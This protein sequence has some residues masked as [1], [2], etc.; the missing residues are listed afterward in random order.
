MRPGATTTAA[1]DTDPTSPTLSARGRQAHDRILAAAAEDLAQ[2]GEVEVARVASAAGV[3]TGLPF[4]YFGS[5]SGLVAAVVDDF[6]RRL[7]EAVVY[8]DLP[9]RTWQEREEARVRAWVDFLFADPLAPVVIA[10]MGGDATVAASWTR[11]LAVAVEVG[12]RNIAA[13]QRAGDLPRG[14]D[15]TLLAATVLGGVQA[16]VATALAADPRPTA[17][18]VADNLWRFVLGAAE[19]PPRTKGRR[20]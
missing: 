7:S 16:A 8:R 17:G 2:H 9:G 4:R 5:R 1:L 14:N 12:A 13:G 6:H 18:V 3:S 15:P 19:A 20:T 10:G 11:R